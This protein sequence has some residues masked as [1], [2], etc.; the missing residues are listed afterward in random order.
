MLRDR[1]RARGR[2]RPGP[3]RAIHQHSHLARQQH[4]HRTY[5]PKRNRQGTPRR[6]SGKDSADYPSHHRRNQAQREAAGQHRQV[7]FRDYRNRRNRGRHR[8]APVHRER[9]PATLGARQEVHMHT[10]HL[11]ALHTR[12]QGAENQAYTALGEAA[13]IGGYP[14]RHPDSPHREGH[15]GSHAPQGGPVL[16]RRPRLRY[17]VDR[18]A[19]HLRGAHQDARAKTRRD[20]PAQD[21][22]PIQRR[23]RHGQVESIS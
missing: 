2:P 18:R 8:I 19:H 11:C 4:Y 20:Y 23:A 10:P 5:L 6:L 16:Q 21:R 17:P 12:C 15:T 22:H 13:A 14:A 7:R 1:R 3:L 9:A